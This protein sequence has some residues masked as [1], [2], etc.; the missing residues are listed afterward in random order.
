MK[1]VESSKSGISA[2]TLYNLYLCTGVNT[3]YILFDTSHSTTDTPL[4]KFLTGCN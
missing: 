2:K 3:H 1:D 4:H